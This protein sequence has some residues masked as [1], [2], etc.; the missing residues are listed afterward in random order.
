LLKRIEDLGTAPYVTT[1]DELA[2]LVE[3][4]RMNGHR[5]LSW[6]VSKLSI[7]APP[8]PSTC[9][10]G[11][12]E[13]FASDDPERARRAMEAMLKMGKLDVAELRRAADGVAAG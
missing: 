1:P 11:M 2:V 6:Q 5:L 8:V 3:V 10:E 9:V 13:V 7:C 4:A 12:D